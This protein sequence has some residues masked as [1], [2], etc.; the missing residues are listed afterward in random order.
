MN[1]SPNHQKA[2]QGDFLLFCKAMFE[3]EGKTWLDNWYQNPSY[4]KR[5][6]RSFL[7]NPAHLNTTLIHI[8]LHMLIATRY[9]KYIGCQLVGGICG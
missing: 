5:I 9:Y 4:S 1:I 2:V 6:V 8:V 3:P 7:S